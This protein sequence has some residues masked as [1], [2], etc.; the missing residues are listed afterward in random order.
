MHSLS[1]DPLIHRDL[2]AHNVVLT[3]SLVAK[4]ADYANTALADLASME[5]V[6]S[7]NSKLSVYMAPEYDDECKKCTS[8]DIF[9]FGHLILFCCIQVS[10][11]IILIL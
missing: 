5:C 8:M 2:T 3:A 7:G 6:T 9:S 10:L 11:P 4:I 1:P